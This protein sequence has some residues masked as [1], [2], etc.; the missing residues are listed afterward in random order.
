MLE[1]IQTLDKIYDVV[2]IDGTPS[3]IVSDSIAI[4]KYIKTIIIVSEYKKTKIEILKKLKKQIE[5]VNAKVTGVIINKYPVSEKTYG[6]GYYSDISSTSRKALKETTMRPK[7]VE[8]LIQEAELKEE[9][10]RERSAVKLVPEEYEMD[11]KVASTERIQANA[12]VDEIKNEI[13]MIK[14]LFLQYMMSNNENKALGSGISEK[15]IEDLKDEVEELREFI[16]LRELEKRS[17]EQDLRDELLGLKNMQE[18]IKQIQEINR[19]KADEFI[20]KFKSKT[21]TK[22]NNISE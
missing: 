11:Y 5:S 16:R 13:S 3:A 1:I 21:K 22:A 6:S 4:S 2:I 8:E 14:N 19:A 17:F 20:E 7:T 9:E 10:L 12:S 15:Q 18:E